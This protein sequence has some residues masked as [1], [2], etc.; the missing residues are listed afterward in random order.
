[1]HLLHQ[2]L[3]RRSGFT[4]NAGGDDLFDLVLG[5]CDGPGADLYWS[6]EQA[7]TDKGI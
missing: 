1:V 4:A 7:L 3:D 5:P 6:G 2:S